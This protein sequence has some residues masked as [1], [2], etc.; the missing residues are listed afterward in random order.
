MSDLPRVI[1]IT[2]TPGVGKTSVSD[3]LEIKGYS[4]L[5]FNNFILDE[6]L[7][8]GYDHVRQSVIIDEEIIQQR[9]IEKIE[10]YKN[11][12]FIE[13]HTTAALPSDIISLVI[14]LRCNPMI[15]RERLRSSRDYSKAK[16]DENVQAEIMEEISISSREIYG[17]E[18]VV[19]IDNSNSSLN[20]IIEK[21]LSFL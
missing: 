8:F 6:G 5:K 13:G 4:V 7:Y 17:E 10:L 21:I 20:S 11:L 15:L 2:G 18:K 14:V 1:L 3:L 12:V 19:D 9:I 16:I